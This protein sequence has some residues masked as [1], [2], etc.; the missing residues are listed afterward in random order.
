MKDRLYIVVVGLIMLCIMRL[1]LY[2]YDDKCVWEL[3]I[4]QN[5][6]P[7]LMYKVMLE[8]QKQYYIQ[9]RDMK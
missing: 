6:T 3:T 1:A 4:K 9:R 2:I 5:Q 7:V 8:E